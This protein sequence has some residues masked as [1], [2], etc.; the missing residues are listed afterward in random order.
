MRVSKAVRLIEWQ[1]CSATVYEASF[2]ETQGHGDLGHTHA[3]APP[4]EDIYLYPLHQA[5]KTILRTPCIRR[6]FH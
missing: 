4:E 2:G 3:K 1:S 5:Y 6:L